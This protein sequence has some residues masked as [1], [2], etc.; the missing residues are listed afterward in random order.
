MNWLSRVLAAVWADVTVIRKDLV[1]SWRVLWALTVIESRRKYAGSVLGM[2]WYPM[3]AALLLSSY[4]FVYLIVLRI[5]FKD[6]GTYEY[7]LFVFSGLIPYL[8]F[9]EAVNSSTA[10]VRQN[11]SLL[12]NAVFPVEFVPL[13]FVCAAMFG[14]VS[15]LAILVVM[16]APTRY[17][18]WHVLYLPVPLVGLWLFCVAVA[19]VLSSVAVFLPDVMQVINILLLLLMFVSPVGFSLD[20]VPASARFLVYLNPLTYLIDGFRFAVL[21][22]R[23][24]PLWSDALFL[25]VC[26]VSSALAGSFFRRLSPIFADYE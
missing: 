2:L 9:T 14:L 6:L 10:S 17:V 8:G 25:A 16:I 4:C 26:L 20:M 12:K 22:V 15:S 1:R 11:L 18:G 7:V 3:Y 19:W 5:R 13:K 24:L 21:G 23:F